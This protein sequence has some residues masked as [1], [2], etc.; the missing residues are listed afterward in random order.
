MTGRPRSRASAA[1][2]MEAKK[3]SPSQWTTVRIGKL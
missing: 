1:C 3:R 2:S